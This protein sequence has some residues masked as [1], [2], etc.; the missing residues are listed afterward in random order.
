MGLDMNFYKLKKGTEISEY[1]YKDLSRH[2]PYKYFRKNYTIHDIM[3]LAKMLQEINCD[4]V[5]PLSWVAGYH[6]IGFG[7]FKITKKQY[8][9]IK[10][11]L[12][13]S[14]NELEELLIT[15]DKKDNPQ[16]LLEILKDFD[17]YDFWYSWCD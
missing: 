15:Y 9:F 4:K 16:Q 1:N 14:E 2:K 8:N 17:K 11:I 5:E 7:Y 10:D 13:M 6:L 12:E 3:G